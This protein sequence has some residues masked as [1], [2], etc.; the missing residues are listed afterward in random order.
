MDWPPDPAIWPHAALSRQITQ[1]PHRWH[2]QIMG[3]GPDLLLLHGAGSAVHSWR[4]LMPL[5][6]RSHRVIAVDLPGH[7]FTRSPNGARSGLDAMTQDLAQLIAAQGWRPAA[8]VGHSAG[9]ALALRLAG[10]LDPVPRVLGI[11]AAL[12]PFDGVAGW[13]FPLLA[14]VLAANPLTP[15]LFTLGTSGTRQARRMIEGTGSRLDAEGHALYAR[16]MADR[17]HVNGA[18]QMMARWSLDG[19]LRDLPRITAPTLL[20][21]GDRDRAVA[22][23]VSEAAAVRMPAAQVLPLTGLGHLAHEEDPERLARTM[24][25]FLDGTGPEA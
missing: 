7:G 6:A 2:A 11:N 18:L 9:G 13:L 22:P 3:E 4:G 15:A 23:S 5:L 10:R 19:L 17:R 20:I 1:P 14:R 25:P 21:T 24:A 16:L 12:T 8:L